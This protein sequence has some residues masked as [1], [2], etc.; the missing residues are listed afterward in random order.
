MIRDRSGAAKGLSVQ[1]ACQVL[2]VSRS[3]FY[4]DF[5][6][7]PVCVEGEQERTVLAWA[8]R[9]PV[10]GYRMVAA[11]MRLGGHL[12]ASCKRVRKV[13]RAHG[14]KA[15]KRRRFVRTSLA[16]QGPVHKNLLK[17]A[18][19]S[20]AGQ[21]LVTDLT[22]VATAGGFAYVSVILDAF[23]RRALGYAV[24]KNMNVELMLSS[25]EKALKESPL[26]PGWIHHSDRGSQYTSPAYRQAVLA[27]GGTLSNSAK[28]NPYHNA[29]MESFFKT[30]KAEEAHLSQYESVQEVE[31]EL[32]NFLDDYNRSRPHSSLGYKT[33]SVFEQEL[34]A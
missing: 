13:M 4:E 19:L 15:R 25:L 20:A 30:Y 6:P 12:F 24:G 26:K 10:H 3:V 22:Y 1:R 7:K 34:V 9:Y 5:A 31:Q 27:A 17:E 23:T 29:K 28:G 14:L 16:G 8:H 18:K 11:R 33:P 2:E 32:Q 21:A